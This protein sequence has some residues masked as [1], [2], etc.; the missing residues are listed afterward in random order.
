MEPQSEGELKPT[1][2][3]KRLRLQKLIEF[4]KSKRKASFPEIY[5]FM[6]SRYWLTTR[7]VDSYIKDLEA[8]GIIEVFSSDPYVDNPWA[9]EPRERYVVYKGK[10]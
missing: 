3:S 9:C 1:F 7:T 6:I 8:S 2:K 4:V 10:D 5:Q